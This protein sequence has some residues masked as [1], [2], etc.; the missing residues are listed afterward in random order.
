MERKPKHE[1]TILV[2]KEINLHGGRGL[3]L[4]SR[5]KPSCR[6]IKPTGGGTKS[7]GMESNFPLI[8]MGFTCS[9]GT[10]FWSG[11]K[12]SCRETTFKRWGTESEGRR[13][14]L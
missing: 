9:K 4:S 3:F 5:I 10:F 12:L 14:K 6:E 11:T 7:S 2:A 1:E 13:I 8:E